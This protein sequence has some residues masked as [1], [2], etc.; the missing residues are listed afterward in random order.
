MI[1][2]PRKPTE[3]LVIP[4]TSNLHQRHAAFLRIIL[5]RVMDMLL[6]FLSSSLGTCWHYETLDLAMDNRVRERACLGICML[7]KTKN[8][9]SKLERGYLERI[10]I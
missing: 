2:R 1:A 3:D 6:A 7:L 5:R 8:P 4:G 10:K 9:C